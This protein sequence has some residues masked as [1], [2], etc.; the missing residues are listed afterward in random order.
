M[1]WPISESFEK[2]VARQSS[3]GSKDCFVQIHEQLELPGAS[4]YGRPKVP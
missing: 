3:Q 1:V 4:G 2:G